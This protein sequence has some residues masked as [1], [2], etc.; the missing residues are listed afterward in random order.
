MTQA[1]PIDIPAR[2]ATRNLTTALADIKLAHSVFALPFAL[3]AA[4]LAASPFSNWARFSGQLTLILCCMVLARTWAMLLNRLADRRIDADNPRTAR[5]AL[6]AGRL[7]P[8]AGWTIASLCAL[9]FLAV[10]A[11][12]LL[13]YDN[14]WPITL[15]PLVLAWLALYAYTKRFTFLCHFFLGSALAISP[16]AAVIAINPANLA[17]S[18]TSLAFSAP[19]S[20]TAIAVTFLALFVLLWVAGFDIAYALQDLDFDRSTGL[21]SVPARFGWRGALWT[22]R[23]L[24]TLAFTALILAINTAPPL[25]TITYAAAAL[26]AA[27]LIYEHIVLT[28]RGVAGIPMAF[29]TLNGFISLALGAAGITDT[30]M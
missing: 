9:L 18:A 15:A 12:F 19:I 27:L 16:I 4:F 26:V 11:A 23:A 10:C 30:L 5:R 17:M 20:P 13:I 28:K 25:N 1:T 3:L 21:H 2:S 6:A 14:P 22:A 24:H 29:F 8:R 7:S